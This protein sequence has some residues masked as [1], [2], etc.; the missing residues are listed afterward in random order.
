LTK[1]IS[2]EPSYEADKIGGE[3]YARLRKE[4][5]LINDADIFIA[6]IVKAHSCDPGL[7]TFPGMV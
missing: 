1:E 5:K 4:G 2:F 6:S 3:I 7:E